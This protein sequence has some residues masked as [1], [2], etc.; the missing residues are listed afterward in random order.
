MIINQKYSFIWT[1]DKNIPLQETT[2]EEKKI[3]QT[4]KVINLQDSYFPEDIQEN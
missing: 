2:E 3:S 4:L 1:L